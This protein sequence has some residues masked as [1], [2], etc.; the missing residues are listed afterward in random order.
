MAAIFIRFQR[1]AHERNVTQAIVVGFDDTLRSKVI[2]G[3]R[4]IYL[5]IIYIGR[6]VSS[7]TIR[8]HYECVEFLSKFENG[9]GTRQKDIACLH[10]TLNYVAN[11]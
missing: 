7:T 2:A 3:R 10:K 11:V 4:T 8:L 1:R 9:F 5:F 6:A